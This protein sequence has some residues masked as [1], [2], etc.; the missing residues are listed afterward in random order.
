MKELWKLTLMY[1]GF[2]TQVFID[3]IVVLNSF[4]LI[5]ANGD[6]IVSLIYL[7]DGNYILC[8]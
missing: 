2:H 8:Y 7:S 4:V 5:F 3:N 6:V 1:W